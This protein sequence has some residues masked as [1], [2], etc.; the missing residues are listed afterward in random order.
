MKDTQPA[1]Q[2][3]LAEVHDRVLSDYQQERSVQLARSKADDLAKRTASGEPFDKAAKSLGID[4]KTPEA[5]ARTGSI[6][7]LGSGHQ[8]ASAF[9][10]PVGQ[11]STPTQLGN[12][13]VVYKIV[14]HQPVLPE[15]LVKQKDQIEQQLIQ[16]KQGAAFDAFRT[17]LEDRLTKEGKL[18][19]NNEALKRLNKT[20]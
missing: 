2:G 10:M 4:L 15:D 9:S 20:S 7:D 13:W 1:H 18:T 5:F 14:A 17:A 8:L 19:I 16:A 3:T 11:V 6:P 12:A